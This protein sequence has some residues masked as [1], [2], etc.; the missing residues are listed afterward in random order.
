MSWDRFFRVR[1]QRRY[2]NLGFSI[3]SA[4]AAFGIG[5]PL[6][7]KYDIDSWGAQQVGMDPFIVLGITSAAVAGAGWL[8][9]PMFGNNAVRVWASSKGVTKALTEVCRTR[10]AHRYVTHVDTDKKCA[11]R[12]VVLRPREALQGRSLL[13]E[14]AEPHPRL[15]RR[16]DWQRKGLPTV[17]EGSAS[18]QFEEKQEHAV[19]DSAWE[20][21]KAGVGREHRKR[22][23]QSVLLALCIC[24]S[25]ASHTRDLKSAP[26]ASRVLGCQAR[27]AR[28]AE[29][30]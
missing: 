21:L 15:L 16:E 7:S 29:D 24:T 4:I 27:M 3:A 20:K 28:R 17:A 2:I 26:V 1:R 6:L 9:G 12:E 5:V 19:D 22:T 10:Q 8:A 14:P 13:L 30:A 11:E 18:V 25:V 23:W